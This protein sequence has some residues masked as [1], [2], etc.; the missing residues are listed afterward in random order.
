MRCAFF[1]TLLLTAAVSGRIGWV[2][3]GMAGAAWSAGATAEVTRLAEMVRRATTRWRRRDRG[4]V[5]RLLACPKCR[6]TCVGLS[7]R[8][9]PPRRP[10][11][12]RRVLGWS[13]W[14]LPPP[15]FAM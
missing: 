8:G 6:V 2:L 13:Q 7:H 4:G 10:V 1:M 12:R 15:L 11:M 3:P 9:L 5:L 14:R